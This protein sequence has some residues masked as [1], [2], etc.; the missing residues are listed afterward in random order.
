M[1]TTTVTRAHD[2]LFSSDRDLGISKE[3]L[4]LH[5]PSPPIPFLSFLSTSPALSFPISVLLPPK[6]SWG[7]GSAVSSFSGSRVEPGRKRTVAH[8]KL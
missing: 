2:E 1:E 6:C 5:D 3:F 8:F 7:L 4:E